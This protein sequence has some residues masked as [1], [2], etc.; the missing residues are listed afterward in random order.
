MNELY[1]AFLAALVAPLLIASWRTS[2]AG[3]SA[4]GILMAWMVVRHEPLD[5]PHTLLSFVDAGLVRG[6]LVPILLY[7]VMADRHAPERNDV[8]PPN[9]ISWTVAG[10]LIAVAFSFARRVLPGDE[11]PLALATATS[12]LLLGLF[13]LSTQTGPFSQAIGVLRIENAIA[14]FELGSGQEMPL[15]IHG[16]LVV[17]FVLTAVLLA[18][19]LRWLSEPPPPEPA[20]RRAAL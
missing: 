13:V 7:R 18:R 2:L 14:F 1:F 3:L 4:Q 15:S 11:S 6:V 5:S 12:A 8:I 16:G 19:Y 17:V 20:I 10:V 9:M